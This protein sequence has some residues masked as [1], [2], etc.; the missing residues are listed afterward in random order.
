MTSRRTSVLATVT[1]S[2]AS[3]L[4]FAF[5]FLDCVK[6][7]TMSGPIMSDSPSFRVSASIVSASVLFEVVVEDDLQEAI[8]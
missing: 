1:S 7:I 2:G 6:W 3:I 8:H 5:P 4:I